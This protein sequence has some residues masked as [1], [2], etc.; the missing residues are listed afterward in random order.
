L[1]NPHGLPPT[2]LTLAGCDILAN[3]NRGIAEALRNI[4]IWCPLSEKHISERLFQRKKM[5]EKHK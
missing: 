5:S 3:E 1:D 2:F 4:W